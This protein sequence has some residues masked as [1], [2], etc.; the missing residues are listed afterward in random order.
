MDVSSYG[1]S[2]LLE[3]HVKAAVEE[4]TAILSSR[5]VFTQSPS[6]SI[7]PSETALPGIASID[8]I[9]FSIIPSEAVILTVIDEYEPSGTARRYVPF[10]ISESNVT[11]FP[12][13][14]VALRLA[15]PSSLKD[16]MK[17]PEIGCCASLVK[18]RELISSRLTVNSR[19]EL[20]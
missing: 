7:T 12:D 10:S 2:K 14:C 19:K 16:R 4:D 20:T 6:A 8:L 3:V 9:S 1:S 15:E 5:G 17:S 11:S 18:E 13:D